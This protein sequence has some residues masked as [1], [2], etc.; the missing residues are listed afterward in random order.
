[1]SESIEN[2]EVVELTDE[3]KKKKLEQQIIY[4]SYADQVDLT[5]YPDDA[6]SI[7]L[8][9]TRLN[10]INDFSKFKNLKS[11]CFRGN[12]LKTFI[13]AN[14]DVNKGLDKIKE[15]DFYD[16]QIEKIENLQQFKTLELLDLSFNRF[17]KIE[18]LNELVE[19]K[20]L[21]LVHN[22]FVKMENLECLTKLELLELGDNQLRVIENLSTLQNLTQL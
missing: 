22:H 12:L 10:R 21:F 18:N 8:S 9:M 11:I 6:D 2:K 19:L 3:E 1:M 17:S 14:L 16:N 15:L 20:K 4:Y 7:D 5:I 13:D